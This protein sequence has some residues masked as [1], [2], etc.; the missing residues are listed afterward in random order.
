MS[1]P[2]LELG[3]GK[4][5]GTNFDYVP[6]N[7]QIG[8]SSGVQTYWTDFER[9]GEEEFSISQTPVAGFWEFKTNI[10]FKALGIEWDTKRRKRFLNQMWEIYRYRK[11]GS[12]G[13]V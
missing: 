8:V 10:P 3:N 12:N 11:A 1:N 13:Q 5:P 4:K 9:P 2:G 6:E 7:K